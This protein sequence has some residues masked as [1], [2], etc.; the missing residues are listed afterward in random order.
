MREIKYRGLELMTGNWVYGSHLKTGTGL[1]YIV[2]QNIIADRLP[3]Y[4]VDK[5]TVGQYTGLKDDNGVPIYEGD[6]YHQ[7][8]PNILYVVEYR[9]TGFFGKQ[10]GNSSYAGI[11]HWLDKIEIIGNIYEHPHLLGGESND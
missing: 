8:D 7:G 6:V 1:E 9:G 2:P 4:A 11:D 5:N 10:I 3:Q